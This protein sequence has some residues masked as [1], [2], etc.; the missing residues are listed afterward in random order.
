VVKPGDTILNVV[1]LSARP[2]IEAQVLNK[3]IGF[4][5]T[6][7]RVTVKFDAFP[8]TRYGT[9]D[10]EVVDVSRDANKDD[11]LGL[12][13]PVRVRLEAADIDVEGRRVA[14]AVRAA[15]AHGVD[16]PSVT[17]TG[18]SAGTLHAVTALRC[19]LSTG[20]QVLF[21]TPSLLSLDSPEQC[22]GLSLPT[23]A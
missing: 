2:E 18:R 11:K 14:I 19:A 3:D 21:W 9:V 23:L 7:Q 12:I 5:L 6:G 1:P 4:V 15:L 20:A 16:P 8:F 17:S 13:Y 10:G 22:C